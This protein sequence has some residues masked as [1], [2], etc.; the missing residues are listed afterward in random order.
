M[1]FTKRW[2]SNS[3]D[4]ISL[5]PSSFICKWSFHFY[6]HTGGGCSHVC[7]LLLPSTDPTLGKMPLQSD[8]FVWSDLQSTP[9]G[10]LEYSKTKSR[11]SLPFLLQS[12]TGGLF[13]PFTQLCAFSV[14]AD[15]R[16]SQ[17]ARARRQRLNVTPGAVLCSTGPGPGPTCDISHTTA[18]CGLG[19]PALGSLSLH[20][21]PT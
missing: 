16:P 4:S 18:P 21:N 17:P 5:L 2:D 15:C 11:I 9:L 12:P 19:Q 20:L 13:F 1:I 8:P 3:L 10:I 14:T 7:P 6:I